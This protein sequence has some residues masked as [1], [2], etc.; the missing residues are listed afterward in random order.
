MSP[1]IAVARVEE[2]PPGQGKTIRVGDREVALYNDAGRWFAIDDTCPHQGASLGE[3]TLHEGRVICP[4]HS[5]MFVLRTG[6]CA[7]IP[8]LAVACYPTRRVGDTVEVEIPDAAPDPDR[9]EGE[10][11]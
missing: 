3:G 4:W 6:E 10:A 11:E 7:G 1:W 5:W 8:E 2:L 9:V